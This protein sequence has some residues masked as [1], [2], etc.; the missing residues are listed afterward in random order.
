MRLEKER[1]RSMWKKII[2]LA[3][4][5]IGVLSIGTAY[6]MS[7]NLNLKANGGTLAIKTRETLPRGHKF[8]FGKYNGND[9]AF[10]A[11]KE[12][13]GGILAMSAGPVRR[14]T[15]CTS[16]CLGTIVPYVN[17]TLYQTEQA[18]QRSISSNPIAQKI[19]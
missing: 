7:G 17:T 13:T 1:M 15:I 18:L 10:E 14:T 6:F 3:L 8:A 16:N 2:M 19:A 12:S 5:L 11:I 9:I 4:C